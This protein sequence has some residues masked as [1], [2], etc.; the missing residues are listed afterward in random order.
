[1]FCENCG[2]ELKDN[3][4]CTCMISNEKNETMS[5][6]DVNDPEEIAEAPVFCE[7]CGKVLDENGACDCEEYI[8]FNCP[9]EIGDENEVQEETE[10]PMFCEFCGKSIIETGV[11][12]CEEYIAFY[13]ISKPEDKIEEIVQTP[14]FCEF[15]GKQLATGQ[16]CNC[17][18]SVAFYAS[19]F[20]E[21]IETEEP[22]IEQLVLE[23]EATCECSEEPL[24]ENQDCEI[25]LQETENLSSDELTENELSEENTESE[26]KEV[27][28]API[29]AAEQQEKANTTPSVTLDDKKKKIIAI[30][31][32]VIV[33]AVALFLI[34][35]NN[36]KDLSEI[37]NTNDLTSHAKKI[38]K[39]YGCKNVEVYDSYY[40]VKKD[41]YYY[42][43]E[44][45][46]E[47]VV[48]VIV[49]CE[50]NNEEF[51]SYVDYEVNSLNYEDSSFDLT[52]NFYN[53]GLFT[54]DALT[55]FTDEDLVYDVVEM[56]DEGEEL[57]TELM[58]Y[59]E[60][61]RI[62][63]SQ[64]KEIY[65]E[66][67]ESA[68]DILVNEYDDMFE[69]PDYEY[70][71]T[72]M[73][74]AED[75]SSNYYCLYVLYTCNFEEGHVVQAVEYRN[76]SD[77]YGEFSGL[78]LDENN[79]LQVP[80][81][82][83]INM[84]EGQGV[85]ICGYSDYYID[86]ILYTIYDLTGPYVLGNPYEEDNAIVEEET[87]QP[88]NDEI[89]QFSEFGQTVLSQDK[90]IY[91]GFVENAKTVLIGYNN[92]MDEL[93]GTTSNNDYQYE[94]MV[95]TEAP[96]ED[97]YGL[98][99]MFSLPGEEGYEGVEYS[100]VPYGDGE[101]DCLFIDDNGVLEIPTYTELEDGVSISSYDENTIAQQIKDVGDYYDY[102]L[103][104]PYFVEWAD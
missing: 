39:D 53:G 76:M 61:G 96:N 99:V 58:G 13:G 22:E 93:L 86:D 83:D 7:F 77:E 74:Y 65:K 80:W 68:K 26:T 48:R 81:Y 4:V 42:E 94:K 55:Y 66:F 60:F 40:C 71:F 2:K 75:P 97:Y 11:C 51:Y 36:Q 19:E 47:E 90:E 20:N 28:L 45:D 30:V 37:H 100:N 27:E 63:L 69:W 101:F 88:V 62:V 23:T 18:E 16:N 102:N 17:A 72:D 29:A 56:P 104:E 33:L 49:T 43:S 64:D 89:T 21:I 52:Q 9:A 8:A 67:A 3:E 70:E 25:V 92:S 73:L 95:Y 98:Y 41:D 6:S 78:V 50:N 84:D 85:V 103:T 1:M 34:L 87:T 15:C 79:V 12:D 54:E 38:V 57:D 10:T 5:L 82:S 46:Y 24:T 91:E 31:V 35:G 14:S 44:T 32:G 59:S